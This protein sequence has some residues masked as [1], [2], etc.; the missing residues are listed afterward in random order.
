MKP[1]LLLNSANIS[2][3]GSLQASVAFVCEALRESDYDWYF[4][5][6]PEALANLQDFADEPPAQRLLVTDSSPARSSVTRTNIA[7]FID[8]VDPLALFTFLGPAYQH[9]SRPHMMGVADGW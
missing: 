2:F 3:G 5:L 1:R 7:Q 9:F 6:S 8:A 4:I